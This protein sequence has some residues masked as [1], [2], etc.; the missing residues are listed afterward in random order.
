M[1]E[2]PAEPELYP[3]LPAADVRTWL[4]LADDADVEVVRMAAADYCE[5]QRPDLLAIVLEDGEPVGTLFAATPKIVQA[6]LLAAGRLWARKGSP[7]GLASYG[8]F[9]AAE[10]LRLD[11]DVARLLGVGRHARPAVG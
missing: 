4:Q 6:G 2:P 3:W 1:S 8:E 5:E 7:A 9:G 11:P 10:I